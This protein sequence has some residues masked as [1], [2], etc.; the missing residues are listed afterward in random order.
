M[1]DAYKQK[2]TIRDDP[3]QYGSDG[4]L[5][6]PPGQWSLLDDEVVVSMGLT[7]TDDEKRNEELVALSSDT[8]PVRRR[9]GS[10]VP[11]SAIAAQMSSANLP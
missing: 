4:P 10:V 8:E 7:R 11:V 5:S 2:R 1:V 6:L 9:P 3:G